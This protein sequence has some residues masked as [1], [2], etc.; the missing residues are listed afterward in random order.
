MILANTIA[1]KTVCEYLLDLTPVSHAL[2]HGA[3]QR[4]LK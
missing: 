2:T 1:E 4:Y 3:D